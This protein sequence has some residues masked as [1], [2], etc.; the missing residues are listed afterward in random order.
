MKKVAVLISGHTRDYERT[1]P[2]LS[3]LVKDLDADVFI[4][5]YTRRG[6][7]VRFWQGQNDYN[8]KLTAQDYSNIQQTL[9]PIASHYEEEVTVPDYINNH[10]FQN[11]L[12]KTEGVYCMF[13][14]FWHANE[15]KKKYEEENNFKYPLI[16]R[17][18]FDN[19]YL[20]VDLRYYIKGTVQTA[21]ADNR[22]FMA[23]VF[24][25]CDSNTMDKLASIKNDICKTIIPGDFCNA[26]H[27]MT[28]YAKDKSDGIVI[29]GKVKVRLRDKLFT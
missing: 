22:E 17:T 21:R 27:M 14:K 16:I 15:L 10:Q 28:K 11:K 13:Y 18:R 1:L 25:V 19:E 6:T 23:D 26:E 2:Q 3:K 20:S 24:F 4:S 9:K 8:D 7:G 5:S 12:V 29:D